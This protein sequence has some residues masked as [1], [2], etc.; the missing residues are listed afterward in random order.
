MEFVLVVCTWEEMIDVMEAV[1]ASDAEAGFGCGCYIGVG[2][3]G[4]Q[5]LRNEYNKFRL[6]LEDKCR[7]VI[8][9][10]YGL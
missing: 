3:S 6:K 5:W 1:G 8:I 9:W 4:R 10:Y 2:C 7:G